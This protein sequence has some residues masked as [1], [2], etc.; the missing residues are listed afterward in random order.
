MK[1][2]AY[3]LVVALVLLELSC[4]SKDRIQT[5]QLTDTSID[6]PA[7]LQTRTDDGTLVASPP[8]TDF[9]NLRFTTL[10]VYKDHKRVPGAGINHVNAMADEEHLTLQRFA[11]KVWCDKEEQAT[12]GSPGSRIHFWYVGLDEHLLIVS[13]FVD[14]SRKDDDLTKRVF[15][16]V[17][18]AIHSFRKSQ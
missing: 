15:G 5:I 14:A 13:C 8:R 11:D 1:V 10:T 12:E 6:I 7:F 2:F 16:A 9:V 18:P 17:V 3:L 4:D